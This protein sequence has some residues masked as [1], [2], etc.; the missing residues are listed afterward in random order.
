MCVCVWGGAGGWYGS[1]PD[2][3]AHRI[4]PLQS[5]YKCGDANMQYVGEI[6][7]HWIFFVLINTDFSEESCFIMLFFPE[8]FF[9]Y[10]VWVSILYYNT[11]DSDETLIN[12]Y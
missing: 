12:L 1:P 6:Y 9:F 8:M 4:H 3:S 2:S 7:T 5:A 11:D 10:T